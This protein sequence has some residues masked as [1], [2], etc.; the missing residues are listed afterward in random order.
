M[1]RYYE[2]RQVPAK[3]NASLQ[4]DLVERAL[5]QHTWPDNHSLQRAQQSDRRHVQ[6]LHRSGRHIR[7]QDQ[8]EHG[9]IK[10]VYQTV[11]GLQKSV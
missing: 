2:H 8:E 6:G 5:L 4:D 10:Q 7:G 9:D 11:R 1:H 3:D